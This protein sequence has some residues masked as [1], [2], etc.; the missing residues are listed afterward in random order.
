M[1]TSAIPARLRI[2]SGSDTPDE[3]FVFD[4]DDMSPKNKH[5]GLAVQGFK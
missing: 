5:R 3:I 2:H 1:K 4:G